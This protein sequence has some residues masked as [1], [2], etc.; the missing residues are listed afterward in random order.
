MIEKPFF[1]YRIYSLKIQ[2]TTDIQHPDIMKTLLKSVSVLAALCAFAT[3]ST[4][5]LAQNISLPAPQKTGGM[6]LMEALA[7]R[8][9]ARA[10]NTSRELTPRQMSNLLWAAFGINRDGGKRTAPS[11]SNKQ[12]NDLYVLLKTG[13]Y[14][15]DA[16]ANTLVLVVAGDQRELG[17]TQAFAKTAPFTVLMIADGERMNANVKTR[18]AITAGN[19]EMA[20]SGAG[21]IG[22]NIYLY[23][24]S[25]GLVTVVR[26]SVDRA[27][28]AAALSL[29]PTQWVVLAQSVGYAP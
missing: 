12:E 9:S 20:A 8:S 10:F 24:A 25:E 18:E 26:A 22:Q 13:A 4:S 2:L 16:K 17:G 6:P 19:R 28:I 15:Y 7:K 11:A 5:L 3:A 21:F 14:L 29:K 27:K 1:P 23:C